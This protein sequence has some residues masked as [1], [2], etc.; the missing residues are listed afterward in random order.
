[1][2]K[3]KFVLFF[4]AILSTV[5]ACSRKENDQN[6]G[7]GGTAI[8]NVI[9]KHHGVSINIINAKVFIKYNAQDVPINYDDSASCSL[10]SSQPT[11]IFNGLKT[12]SYYIYCQGFD[13]T[14]K[15]NVKGGMPYTISNE[16]NISL[17]LP[18]TEGD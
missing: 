16:T 15:Q 13:T 5:S 4:I 7:K 17:S 6:A 8:L 3:I 11:A 12:G 10:L 18:V 2:R 14:I 1:M 9:P